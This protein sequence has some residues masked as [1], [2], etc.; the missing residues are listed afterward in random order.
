MKKHLKVYECNEPRK[1]VPPMICEIEASPKNVA[2]F[3]AS[4]D[5]NKNYALC[6]EL[7]ICQVTTIGCFADIIYDEKF[8]LDVMKYLVPM[9]LEEMK[10]PKIKYKTCPEKIKYG[11][12]R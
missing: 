5:H 9:Q 11:L 1:G 4:C 8:R 7:D 2:A 12:E 3:I 6:D 10:I